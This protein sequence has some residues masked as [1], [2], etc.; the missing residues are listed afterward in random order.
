RTAI[1]DAARVTFAASGFDGASIRRIAAA[2]GVDPALVHH[3]FGTKDELFLAT[4]DLP[5]D[6]PT[7]LASIVAAGPDG[8]G[9]RLA[10]LIVTVWESPMAA[11]LAGWLRT[12]LADEQ[13]AALI[14][15]FVLARMVGPFTAAL[16]IPEPE[17]TRRAGLV[18]SQILG[19]IVSRYLLFLDPVV[20]LTR[21]QLIAS[22]GQTLQRYLT[23]PLP[24][25]GR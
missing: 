11:G 12:A 20:Q 8:V 16:G 9:V 10:T 23:G 14:R 2:A 7:M 21:E 15:Q 13:R 24:A 19:V 17:R 1:L 3:Y 22:V 6:L 4:I 25:T 5:I 18:M